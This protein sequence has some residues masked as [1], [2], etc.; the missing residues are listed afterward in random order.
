MEGNGPSRSLRILSLGGCLLMNALSYHL[1]AMK[2]PF[3]AL[4]LLHRTT[5]HFVLCPQ[6]WGMHLL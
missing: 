2:S 4:V 6:R 3:L 1:V 5:Q